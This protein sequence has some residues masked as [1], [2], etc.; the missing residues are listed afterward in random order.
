MYRDNDVL[1]LSVLELARF[2]CISDCQTAMIVFAVT[3]R[4]LINQMLFR[5]SSYSGGFRIKSFG[6]TGEE[7]FGFFS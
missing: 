4:V 3:L 1:E 2:N 6:Q 5:H 7:E